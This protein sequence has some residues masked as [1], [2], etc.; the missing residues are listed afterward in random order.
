MLYIGTSISLRVCNVQEFQKKRRKWHREFYHHGF[1]EDY[2][3]ESD[4]KGRSLSR[5]DRGGTLEV[6]N[7]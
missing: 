1:Q 6:R 5:E 3:F 2:K 4:L 7:S